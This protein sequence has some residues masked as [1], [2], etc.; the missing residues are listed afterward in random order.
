[1]NN[2]KV[3]LLLFVFFSN[4]SFSSEEKR[5]V[6]YFN[7]LLTNEY[8]GWFK[9][10]PFKSRDQV[11]KEFDSIMRAAAGC[12]DAR[13]QYFAIGEESSRGV[14][15]CNR[16]SE[17]KSTFFP[18]IALTDQKHYLDKEFISRLKL[19]YEYDIMD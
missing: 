6:K 14:S 1:V 18:R 7:N 9:P 12:A 15:Y 10:K 17:F 2:S 13:F 11:R 8:S 3:L 16:V 19:F 4:S 5:L